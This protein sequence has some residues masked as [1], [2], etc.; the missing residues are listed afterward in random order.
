[1]SIKENKDYL[2]S[3]VDRIFGKGGTN[4]HEALLISEK[5]LNSDNRDVDKHI[6]VLTDGMPTYYLVGDKSLEY[7]TK[8]NTKIQVNG[9]LGGDG[10]TVNNDT[11]NPV[12]NKIDNLKSISK[13]H[14]VG[15]NTTVGDIDTEFFNTIKSK[16]A[17]ISEII[18]S[19]D[20]LKP[21]FEK[22]YQSI[23]KSVVYSSITFEQQ[24]PSQLSVD[25]LYIGNNK[26]DSNQY[27]IENG[28]LIVNLDNIV[29]E[30]KSYTRTSNN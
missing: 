19:T 3:L 21:L 13:V 6:I 1:M 27:T 2:I 29:F 24:I 5:H 20:K 4:I 25:E 12:L 10:S 9:K 23:T 22:I 8:Y 28:K 15:L 14:F 30:N 26:L 17:G 7:N 16:N 18:D 11:K